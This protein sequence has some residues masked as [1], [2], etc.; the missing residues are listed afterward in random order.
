MPR[1]GEWGEDGEEDKNKDKDK[2]EDKEKDRAKA[3]TMIRTGTGTGRRRTD[4]CQTEDSGPPNTRGANIE[5]EE[6]EE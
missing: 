2:G 6:Q 3:R 1:T 4:E 5:R